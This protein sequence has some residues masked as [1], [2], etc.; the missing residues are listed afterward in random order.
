MIVLGLAYIFYDSWIAILGLFPVLFLFFKIWY[1][2][3][4]NKK[5]SLFREQFKDGMQAVAVAL[6]VGY[7]VENAITEAKKDLS[8]IYP[9]DSRIMKEFS[10]MINQME[11]NLTVEQ[12]LRN[13]SKNV[14]QED[15]ESFV[16][17]FSIAK[18]VGGDS[19]EILKTTARA[20]SEKIEIEKEIQTL[21]AA[22]EFEFNIMSLVPFAIILYMRVTFPDFMNILY[23]N[24]LGIVIM[25]GCLV[26]Y[27]F[28][29][30]LGRKIVKIEV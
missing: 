18:R 9:E 14:K 26:V 29:F 12:A 17:V 30:W 22:K 1:I 21:L 15:V 24:P 25:S 28:A 13:F 3:C 2:S 16:T 4:T 19:I 20:I 23:G 27:G 5:E 7:S 8:R 6:N 11:M 10:Q